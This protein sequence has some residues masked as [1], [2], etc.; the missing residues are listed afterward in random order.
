MLKQLTLR[1]FDEAVAREIERVAREEG[2]S[3]NQSVQKLLRRGLAQSDNGVADG[4]IGDSLDHLIGTWTAEE[5]DEF[6]R[7]VADFDVIDESMWE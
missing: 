1:G 7:A 2:V 5:A 6:D 3:L 4:V